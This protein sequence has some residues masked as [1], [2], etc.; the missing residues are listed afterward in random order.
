MS[1]KQ[2]FDDE[3]EPT[4]LAVRVARGLIAALAIGGMLWLFGFDG[5]FRFQRTSPAV[6]QQ[7]PQATDAPSISIPLNVLV[8]RS[9]EGGSERSVADIMRLVDNADR[10]LRQAQLS[11]NLIAIHEE[12][13]SPAHLASYYDNPYG[14]ITGFTTFDPATINVVLIETIGGG[15]NG[16]SYGGVSAV[17]VA[18]FTSVFDFRVLAHEIG[19]QLSLGHVAGDQSRLMFRGANG[20]DLTNDEIRQARIVAT[21]R[22]GDKQLTQ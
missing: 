21:Q 7:L 5:F 18:D 16:I 1:D 2:H 4:P 11:L 9:P 8:V 14:F 12:E 15:I 19:H 13:V 20:F 6:T 3:Y 10:V 17:A 22:F